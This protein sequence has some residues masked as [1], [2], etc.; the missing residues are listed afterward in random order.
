MEAALVLFQKASALNPD[1]PCT[2]QNNADA[3]LGYSTE[4]GARSESTLLYGD[5]PLYVQPMT[6]G[7]LAGAVLGALAVCLLLAGLIHHCITSNANSK[8]VIP[9]GLDKLRALDVRPPLPRAHTCIVHA[10]MLLP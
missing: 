6:G 4:L 8:R 5:N 7:E 9:L 2:D 3:T 1:V 10:C